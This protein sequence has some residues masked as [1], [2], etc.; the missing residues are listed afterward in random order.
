MQR[1][2]ALIMLIP[3]GGCHDGPARQQDGATVTRMTAASAVPPVPA[4]QPVQAPPA[5]APAPELVGA[6]VARAQWAR[7][8]DGKSGKTPRCAPLALA[9]A[10][11]ADG[12]PRA[13]D[14]SGGWGVAFDLPN[15]RSAYGFAGPGVLPDDETPPEAQRTRLARQWPYMQELDQLPAPSFAGYGLS[16][17]EPYPEDNPEGHGLQS[18][19]YVHV[20]GQTCTYNVWSRISRAHLQALLGNLRLLD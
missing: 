19:A 2:L 14:F 16:G 7:S 11:G 10:A 3:L 9:S 6:D 15:L 1:A 12:V 18:I 8:D 4:P 17:A 5:P 13:A 20:G